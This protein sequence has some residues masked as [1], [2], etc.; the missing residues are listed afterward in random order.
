MVGELPDKTSRYGQKQEKKEDRQQLNGR[1]NPHHCRMP[2]AVLVQRTIVWP[3]NLFRRTKRSTPIWPR[4]TSTLPWSSR[5]AS[6]GSDSPSGGVENS[7]ACPSSSSGWPLMVSRKNWR[8]YF[9]SHFRKH[10]QSNFLHR[11]GRPG[12]P[13]TSGWPADRD[14]RAHDEEHDPRRGHRADQERWSGRSA[15]SQT[16]ARSQHSLPGYVYASRHSRDGL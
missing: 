6:V 5:E 13:V 16:G 15:A 12:R 8:T 9:L 4:T 11:T 7:T 14:Q 10:H 3:D 1:L 2:L